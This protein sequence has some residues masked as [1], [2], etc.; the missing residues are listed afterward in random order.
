M[1]TFAATWRGAWNPCTYL[2]PDET[3]IFWTGTGELHMTY[4]PRKPTPYGIMLKSLCCGDSKIMLAAEVSESKDVMA[5]KEYRDVTGAS[6][7][8]TL[9]LTKYWA[10]SGRTV[11]ADSWFGSC[12]TAE[13]LMDVHGLH[14]ILCVKNG[15]AGYPK[16]KMR[17]ALGGVRHKQVFFKVDVELE[18]GT[19]TFYAGGHQDRKPLHLIATCGT[20][21]QGES[22]TRYRRDMEAGQI[23]RQTYTLEQPVM[24]SLYR[25]KFNAVD[26]FNRDAM[27]PLSVQYAIKTKSWYRRLFL[28]LLGMAETNAMLA[29]RK[30]KG[31]IQRYEWLCMLSEALIHNVWV[32][33]ELVGDVDAPAGGLETHNNLFYHEHHFKCSRCPRRTHYKCGCGVAL[34]HPG[35]SAKQVK[36]P[37]YSEHLWE[38]FQARGDE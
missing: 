13:F 35:C 20:S 8:T 27:G 34:C 23:V 30:A 21:L 11:I 32:D 25:S 24:H 14:S 31:E 37:C 1:D 16:A 29:Y 9:R 2:V 12:N 28:A 5:T 26:L 33:N 38:V 17:E 15:S 10:G 6:T 18:R 22:R 7:A 19:H 36:G 3:M 4:L